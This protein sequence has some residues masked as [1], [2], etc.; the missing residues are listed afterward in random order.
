MRTGI[1]SASEARDHLPDALN[2]VAFAGERVVI[3]RR[4]KPVAALVSLEDLELL[5]SLEDRSD[6]TAARKALKEKGR[7]PWAEL[8]AELGL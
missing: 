1:L 4:G 3:E 8:K 2:R 6:L 5:R 7:L